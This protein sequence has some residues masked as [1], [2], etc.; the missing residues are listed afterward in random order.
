M[1]DVMAVNGNMLLKMLEPVLRPGSPLT[2]GGVARQARQ[3]VEQQSFESLLAGQVESQQQQ[4][5][6]AGGSGQNTNVADA[7]EAITDAGQSQN[8]SRSQSQN[9]SAGPL[10]ELARF[11]QIQ[12]SSL[13]SLMSSQ[14]KQQ[15]VTQPNAAAGQP[16]ADTP[17][18]HGAGDSLAQFLNDV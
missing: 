7:L 2:P 3:P 8:P 16:A 9:Q 6:I 5:V 13:R 4:T 15:D 14:R 18:G 12:N 1:K 10:G 11:D 17:A